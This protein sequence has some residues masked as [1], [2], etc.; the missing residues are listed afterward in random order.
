MKDPK[1]K[2]YG[3]RLNFYES[4]VIRKYANENNLQDHIFINSCAVTNKTISDLKHEIRKIK[5]D[6]Q[7]SQLILTGCAAPVSY[8]HLTLPT[9]Y[10]V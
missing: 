8:T 9:T 5:N 1:I 6:N 2:T 3:C 7:Q 4:E 10:H